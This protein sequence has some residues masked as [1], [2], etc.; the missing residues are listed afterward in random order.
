MLLGPCPH[1]REQGKGTYWAW[2]SSTKCDRMCRSEASRQ[3]LL[4]HD[5]AGRPLHIL[6]TFSLISLWDGHELHSAKRWPSHHNEIIK[7]KCEND[8]PFVTFHAWLY[9]KRI[10]KDKDL[11]A[12]HE[13]QTRSRST[14]QISFSFLPLSECTRNYEWEKKKNKWPLGPGQCTHIQFIWMDRTT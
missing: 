7:R 3:S 10:G 8:S 2:A 4:M 13:S 1:Y 9:H 11:R 5:W 6:C 12:M 14:V